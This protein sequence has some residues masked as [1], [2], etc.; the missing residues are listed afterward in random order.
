MKLS[1]VICTYNRCNILKLALESME[2]QTAKKDL[3]EILIIDNNS[4]DN[5]KNIVEPFLKKNKNFKYIIETKQGLSHSRN[6]GY[7]NASASYVAYIDDD[8][9]ADE[10]WINEAIKVIKE[11]QPDIFGGPIYPYYLNEKPAWFKDEYE[12]MIAANK[13][14]IL[15]KGFLNGSNIVFLKKILIEYNGFD[16]NFGMTGDNFG[17][18]EET[19]F[20]ERA[21]KEGKKLYYSSTMVMKHL[22][23][24][25]KKTILYNLS[26]SYHSGKAGVN[27]WHPSYNLETL[28][29]LLKKIDS[30]FAEFSFSLRKRDNKKYSYPENY[31]IEN[32]HSNFFEVGFISETLMKKTLDELVYDYLD[33]NKFFIIKYIR[34]RKRVFYTIKKIII[35][36]IK[37]ST[38]FITKIF[39]KKVK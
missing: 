28:Y 10:N 36:L 23:A 17:Y 24:E 25:Y 39:K 5:T 31:I 21:R 16:P 34:D 26:T 8:A 2:K 22:V 11:E 13:T 4:T 35:L 37:K 19:A 9:K 3:F 33:N 15:E 18:H 27:L 38:N 12:Y 6:A 14:G 30:K 20:I 7:K 29:I 1:V 32:K